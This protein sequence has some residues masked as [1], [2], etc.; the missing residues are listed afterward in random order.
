MNL[1][2]LSDVHGTYKTPV[3]RKDRVGEAFEQKIDFVFRYAKEHGCVILQAGDLGDTSRN[4]EVL[5][6]MIN[7]LR[8]YQVI[9][10]GVYGQHDLYMRRD[11]DETP[12][13]LSVL[14]HSTQMMQLGKQPVHMNN[15]AIYGSSWNGPIP[16]VKP[17]GQ[18]RNV[19]VLHAPIA[20]RAEYPGHDFTDP[21]QFL[22]RHKGFDLVLAGDVHRHFCYVT[23]KYL[24]DRRYVINTGPVLRLEASRYMMRHKPCFYV[25]DTNDNSIE[26]VIIPHAPSKKVLTREHIV[27]KNISSTEL[28]QFANSIKTMTSMTQNRDAKLKKFVRA[29]VKSRRV[30]RIIKEVM[31]GKFDSTIGRHRRTGASI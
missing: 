6:Y 3:S 29:N 4:W 18:K 8:Q 13:A 12:T 24:M 22:E 21:D 20:R 5:H 2:L 11:P 17:G 30:R 1:L 10:L 7:V 16:K 31:R 26:K 25:Y 15:V 19:L 23:G 9:M 28:E 14:M 27:Q